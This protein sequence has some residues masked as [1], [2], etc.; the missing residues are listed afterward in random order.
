MEKTLTINGAFAE[1]TVTV[2]VA[3]PE[4][5]IDAPITDWP[6]AMDRVTRYFY[7]MVNYTESVRDA[8]LARGDG[9]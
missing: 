5:P 7:D 4:D 6:P 1:W 9:R 8:E 2:T 3:P